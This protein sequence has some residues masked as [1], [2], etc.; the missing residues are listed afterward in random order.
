[1]GANLI[2]VFQ[3]FLVGIL[4]L[5]K[6]KGQKEVCARARL[7]VRQLSL[8]ELGKLKRPIP[9]PEL[10][11]I[12]DA[13]E[14]TTA[15]V[16]LT[17]SY[18]EGL[19]DQDCYVDP[20]SAAATEALIADTARQLRLCHRA[21]GGFVD[22]RYPPPY[23]VESERQTALESWQRIADLK[24][25]EDFSLVLSRSRDFQTWAMVERLCEESEH[26]ASKDV[27][28]AGLL[29]RLAVDLP[30]RLQ[31]PEPWKLKLIGYAKPHQGNV[32]RVLGDF[33]SAD[34]AFVEAWSLWDSGYDPDEL[35]DPGRILELEAS[36]RRDQGCFPDAM[37][38]LRQ[39]E[40]I[41]RRPLYVAIK[42]AK[43]LEAMGDY[44]PAIT[45]LVKLAPQAEIH[46]EPRLRNMPRW[47]LAVLLTYVGRH[48][49][50]ALLLPEVRRAAR[51]LQDKLD[52]VRLRW[53]E[54]RVAAGL[55]QT[56][57]ALRA[58]EE[59]RS[60]FASHA[61]HYDVAVTLLETAA[62]HLERGEL[63][64]VQVLAGELA[65]IFEAKGVHVHALAALQL[66]VEAVARQTATAALARRLLDY[67]FRAR[68][69]DK[70]QFSL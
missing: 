14:C 65:P 44:E 57:A 23:A 50:A 58:F 8:L 67:L 3:S 19:S 25:Y 46:P 69:D 26:A 55:G 66:F 29:A 62:I 27:E 22:A 59:A 28:R 31:V 2:S 6:R 20:V 61:M 45:I 52:L 60:G 63:A 40:P 18:L 7:S 56:D 36:F 9:S 30:S 11:R 49:E 37:A 41:S 13:L 68:H 24:S 54:G 38:L 43:T 1:V 47:N 51:E 39:A 16:I 48:R 35:L 15:E 21:P 70:L 17:A 33:A 5:V 32:F 34:A 10:T 53:L 64:T 12:L 42:K 4:R